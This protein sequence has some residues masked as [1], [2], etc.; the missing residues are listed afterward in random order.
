LSFA[1]LDSCLD[2]YI[3]SR[4]RTRWP[5]WGLAI[6][7]VFGIAYFALFFTYLGLGKPFPQGQTYWNLSAD[8]AAIFIY[9]FLVLLG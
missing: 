2:T 6:R 9:V 3:L 5:I 7:L 4:T 1:G 8:G